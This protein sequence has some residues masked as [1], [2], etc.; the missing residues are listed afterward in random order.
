ML[1][2]V[3]THTINFSSAQGSLILV[4]LSFHKASSH[5]PLVDRTVPASFAVRSKAFRLLM[6]I[7]EDPLVNCSIQHTHSFYF[8]REAFSR[9]GYHYFYGFGAIR[10]STNGRLM[11]NGHV[12]PQKN[13]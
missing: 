10:S 11:M 2:H 9:D 3:A 8:E 12:W 6:Y 5:R 13:G 7:R 1:L 4:V